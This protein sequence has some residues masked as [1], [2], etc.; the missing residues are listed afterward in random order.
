MEPARYVNPGDCIVSAEDRKAALERGDMKESEYCSA[1]TPQKG[2]RQPIVKMIDHL[3]HLG[4]KDCEDVSNWCSEYDAASKNVE[5][6]KSLCDILPPTIAELKERKPVKHLAP[7]DSTIEKSKTSRIIEADLRRQMEK[8]WPKEPGADH[9]EA[10]EHNSKYKWPEST[11]VH[12]YTE[13]DHER[14][15]NP[16][17]I[18]GECL[19]SPPYC[20]D[21]DPVVEEKPTHIRTKEITPSTLNLFEIQPPPVPPE[22]IHLRTPYASYDVKTITADDGLGKATKKT[23]P[24]KVSVWIC[25]LTLVGSSSVAFP[26]LPPLFFLSSS[27]F[28]NSFM[29][30]T[31]LVCYP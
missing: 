11:G 30:L 10:T 1:F 7:S 18:K 14:D 27:V 3:E 22:E 5:L 29:I 28:G 31:F 15:L 16:E 26:S 13:L 24:R 2:G 8:I 21:T 6:G 23:V 9:P 19:V 12:H 17:V 25:R 4:S 20:L